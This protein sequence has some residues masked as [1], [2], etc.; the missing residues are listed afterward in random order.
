MQSEIVKFRNEVADKLRERT[1][2]N[3][4]TDALQAE[5]DE[6]MSKIAELVDL[7]SL[8][9]D[10]DG[11]GGMMNLAPQID[12]I[13]IESKSSP[14]TE[15]NMPSGISFNLS[16]HPM[17]VTPNGGEGYLQELSGIRNREPYFST[18]SDDESIA[19]LVLLMAN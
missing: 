8:F 3:R 7:D 12:Y 19:R 6:R 1:E 15:I 14:L 16:I 11:P 9:E 2:A 17:G 10:G 18:S 4:S 13:R 5:L